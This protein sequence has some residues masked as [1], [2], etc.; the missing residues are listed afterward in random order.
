M[1]FCRA[2]LPESWDWPGEPSQHELTLNSLVLIKFNVKFCILLHSIAGPILIFFFFNQRIY[3][4]DL[5]VFQDYIRLICGPEDKGD[6][7]GLVDIRVLG[8]S[9]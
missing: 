8:E 5:S 9:L 4:K 6:K 7:P 1:S 2:P 3:P